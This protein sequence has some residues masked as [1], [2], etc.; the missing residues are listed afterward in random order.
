[1]M[2]KILITTAVIGLTSMLQAGMGD[3][4]LYTKV[5]IDELEYQNNDEKNVAWDTNAWIGYDLNKI[6]IYSEG[7]K[8][9]DGSAQ[10]ENQL[11]YSK[12]I[13]PYWDVQ[14]GVGYD[15]TATDSQTWGVIALQG[16]APYFFETR[17][18]LLI[19]DDGNIG[20]RLEAEYEALFTQK[21]I[22]TPSISAN[23]YSKDNPT[24]GLGKGLSNLTTGM[25]LRYE[26][27]REFAPYVGVEWSKN[28]GNTADLAPLDEGY[29]VGGVRIWF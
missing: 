5:T 23:L 11:V 26:I 2:K 15:K 28:F 22:L 19:G 6:Y 20:L 7:E 21:L 16:L 25:R 12:A 3:D 14:F 10:S 13:A 29:V 4:P 18:A 9:K 27:K 17:G 8:P 1:M 24:M